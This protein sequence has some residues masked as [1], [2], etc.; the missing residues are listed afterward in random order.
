MNTLESCTNALL[1]HISTRVSLNS[2][3]NALLAESCKAAFGHLFVAN[4]PATRA[5]MQPVM[6]PVASKGKGT[7]KVNG[8]NVYVS[9]ET[10]R[11]KQVA[12]AAHKTPN[13]IEMRQAI[14]AAWNSLEEE[15]KEPYRAKAAAINVQRGTVTSPKRGLNGWTYFIRVTGQSMP[16]GT[17]GKIV[18]NAMSTASA[19]WK[20][21]STAEK[22]EWGRK[23]K[24]CNEGGAIATESVAKSTEDQLLSDIGDDAQVDPLGAEEE[25]LV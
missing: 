21:M 16:K 11:M 14:T 17:N 24:M 9:E 15:K 25:I 3:L 6:V 1:A 22:E 13:G 4:A 2:E 10:A 18:G 20:A 19:K 23:A 12:K 5:L 7:G 8:Y